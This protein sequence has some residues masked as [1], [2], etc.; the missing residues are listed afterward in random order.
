MQC[1]PAPIPRPKACASSAAILRLPEVGGNRS[2]FGFEAV[3]ILLV[4][5]LFAG[6][7]TN[8]FRGVSTSELIL[9]HCELTRE[10]GDFH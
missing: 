1:A 3:E 10:L 4:P 5:L 7:A 2:G 6:S 8:E 9:R